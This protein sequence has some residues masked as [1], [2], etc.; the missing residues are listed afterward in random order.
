MSMS[1]REL[2]IQKSE[3]IVRLSTELANAEKA[4]FHLAAAQRELGKAASNSVRFCIELQRAQDEVKRLTKANEKLHAKCAEMRQH[5]VLPA[6]NRK[7]F[8]CVVCNNGQPRDEG[9]VACT[10]DGTEKHSAECILAGENPGAALLEEL[11]ALR[12][13]LKRAEKTCA[14]VYQ[15]AGANDFPVELLDNLSLIMESDQGKETAERPYHEELPVSID[16][17][18]TQRDRNA[19]LEKERDALSET[20]NGILYKDQPI[21]KY[22]AALE[23]LRKAIEAEC[24]CPENAWTGDELSESTC[25]LS[26][27]L[28][29]ALA[30][31]PKAKE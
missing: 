1:E 23:R 21:L 17:H 18:Q 9:E 10:Q 13:R 27:E 8:Y 26:E 3:E 14:V 5:L 6:I 16:L 19:V 7:G 15:W 11:T 12:E 24:T 30:A 4:S 29:V 2:Q 25:A 20:I 28:H 31:C 22:I